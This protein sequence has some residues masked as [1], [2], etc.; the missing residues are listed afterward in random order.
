MALSGT[1]LIQGCLRAD[2]G[3]RAEFV[4]RFQGN[5]TSVLTKIAF[6]EGRPSRD[7]LLELRQEVYLKIFAADCTVLRK[8]RSSEEAAIAAL[9]QSI[10]YS[11]AY[12]YFRRSGALKRGGARRIVSLEDPANSESF[13]AAGADDPLRSILFSEID[14]MLGQV[15]DPL[16]LPQQRT[17]FWLYFRHGFTAG[18][19]A[20]L[21][22][23]GLSE[24][25]VESLLRRLTKGVRERLG[26][27]RASGEGKSVRIASG[28]TSEC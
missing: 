11:V 5:I 3:A 2:A 4:A 24:K 7:L 27:G 22:F 8:L 15:A 28:G 19:I 20:R 9:V 13:A 16:R 12:D 6:R 21:R 25:G 26:L 1:E 23:S 17:V 18:D 14:R 10:A